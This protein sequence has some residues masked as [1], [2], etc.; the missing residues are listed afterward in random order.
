VA[1]D[2]G[3]PVAW[4]NSIH[5][6]VGSVPCSW[7]GW[8]GNAATFDCIAPSTAGSYP[9]SCQ[10]VDLAPHEFCPLT[11]TVGNV[12]VQAPSSGSNGSTSGSSSAADDSGSYTP[13]GY[14]LVWED[15]FDTGTVPSSSTWSMYDSPGNG[16]FGLRRPS[17]FSVHDGMV[18]VVA[19]MESG[20]L[21]SGG[22]MSSQSLLYGYLEFR[23]RSEPDPS[24]ATSAVVLTWPND[25]IWPEHG[26]NDIYETGPGLNWGSWNRQSF[27]TS[28]H[29]GTSPSTIY[30]FDNVV[31]GTQWHVLGMEWTPTQLAFYRDG[32]HI[33]TVTDPTAIPHVSHGVCIQLDAFSQTMGAPVHMYVDWVKVFAQ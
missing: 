11:D 21:V 23:V 18:D 16:T 19:Q 30:Q 5:A 12:T 25:G 29:Y 27:T 13:A 26:E 6:S 32:M 28:V 14:H 1:C 8:Q 20:Q 33:G 4:T 10:L 7:T 9:V 3:A 2:Y 17:A 31:D 24:K 15:L 22:M